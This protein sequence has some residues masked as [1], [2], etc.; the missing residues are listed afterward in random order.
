MA[1]I[2]EKETGVAEERRVVASVFVKPPGARDAPAGPTD[3]DLWDHK[4]EGV[5]GRGLRQSELRRATPWNTYVIEGLR[6][7][8]SP[9]PDG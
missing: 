9:I 7:R 5:L 1:S 8:P 4:G 2:V 6:P 3:G